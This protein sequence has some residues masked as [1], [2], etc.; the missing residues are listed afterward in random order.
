MINDIR[1]PDRV[2]K[3]IP[4]LLAHTR[5]GRLCMMHRIFACDYVFLVGFYLTTSVGL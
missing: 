3:K 4:L 5:A 2:L 1:R